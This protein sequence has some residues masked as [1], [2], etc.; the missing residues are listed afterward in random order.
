[1]REYFFFPPL[2]SAVVQTVM[3]LAV[4]GK[5]ALAL[6]LPPEIPPPSSPSSLEELEVLD[7]AEEVEVA[8]READVEVEEESLVSD[9]VS[10]LADAESD[11]DAASARGLQVFRRVMA[12]GRGTDG[13]GASTGARASSS[14]RATI[15]CF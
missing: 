9:A 3:E 15:A 10:E 4:T 8:V 14:A 11:S 13:T 6:P 12:L 7:A 2:S 1:M 5:R